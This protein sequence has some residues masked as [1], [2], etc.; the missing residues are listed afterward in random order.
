[1]IYDS[2][3]YTILFAALVASMLAIRLGSTLYQ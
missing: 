2:Q 3:V 1:M